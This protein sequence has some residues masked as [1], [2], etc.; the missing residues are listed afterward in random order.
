MRPK[1]T[2]T[3]V[4]GARTASSTIWHSMRAHRLPLGSEKKTP[5]QRRLLPAEYN[6]RKR[7]VHEL[8]CEYELKLI[9]IP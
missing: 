5:D 2:I 8:R 4:A 1:R 6:A 3:V 9:V 7:G